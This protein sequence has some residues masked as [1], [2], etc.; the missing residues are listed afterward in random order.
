MRVKSAALMTGLV[1]Q[2]F[3][4][5]MIARLDVATL[6]LRV[7]MLSQLIPL[8][9]PA[10]RLLYAFPAK[11]SMHIFEL[12]RRLLSCLLHLFLSLVVAALLWRERRGTYLPQPSNHQ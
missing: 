2:I 3:N 6:V 4:I 10:I 8:L 1:A 12:V 11:D 7:F 5:A 9:L